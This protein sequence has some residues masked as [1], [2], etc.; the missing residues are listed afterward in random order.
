MHAHDAAE[1]RSG[2]RWE[3]G[4][5]ER[6]AFLVHTSS[7][8]EM[9][10]HGETDEVGDGLGVPGVGAELLEHG[11]AVDIA[12]EVEADEIRLLPGEMNMWLT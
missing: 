9:G 11:W 7:R 10:V 3:R 8:G 6:D 1:E 12:P 5:V 4:V 2:V